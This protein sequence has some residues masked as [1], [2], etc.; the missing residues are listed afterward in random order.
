MYVKSPHHKILCNFS[1][2]LRLQT[3]SLDNPE[4]SF[5]LLNK[6]NCSFRHIK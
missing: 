3:L 5:V 1:V 2:R 6:L 4:G